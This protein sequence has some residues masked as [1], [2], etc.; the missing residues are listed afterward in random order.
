MIGKQK[1]QHT[2]IKNN[3][4][5]SAVIGSNVPKELAQNR[6]NQTH[7]HQIG[8]KGKKETKL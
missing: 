2:H 5:K 4:S 3:N 8:E 7:N 6:H 1:C